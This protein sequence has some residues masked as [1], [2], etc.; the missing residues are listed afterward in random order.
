MGNS[1]RRGSL[2]DGASAPALGEQVTVLAEL[3]HGRVEQILS[4]T[5]EG[6]ADYDQPHDELVVVVQGGA[7]L[8][9]GGDEVELAQGDWLLLPAGCPHTLLET[10]AGTSWLAV[11]FAPASAA[12]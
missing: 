6:S 2:A 10:R 8:L 11:H 9:V 5:L 7:R 3:A 1:Y 4:G 12:E